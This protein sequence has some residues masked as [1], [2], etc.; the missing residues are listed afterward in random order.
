MK[1]DRTSGSGL[2]KTAFYIWNGYSRC[3]DRFESIFLQSSVIKLSKVP[4]DILSACLEGSF[5]VR[6][7]RTSDG[8]V[9]SGSALFGSIKRSFCR[10]E[11]LIVSY[12]E[13][14]G[15]RRIAAEIDAVLV[16]VGAFLS[17]TD[18]DTIGDN[19]KIIGIL[20]RCRRTK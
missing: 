7:S 9:Y 12:Y 6:I 10:A 5:L 1:R 2:V 11:S 13:G 15:F 18:W 19:S 8:R 17:G 4:A 20:R 3:V 14:S 16:H